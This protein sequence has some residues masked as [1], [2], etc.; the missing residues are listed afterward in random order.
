[1]A[2]GNPA[3]AGMARSIIEN[4]SKRGAGPSTTGGAGGIAPAMAQ[5]ALSSRMNE[6]QGSDPGAVLR[7]LEQMKQDVVQLIPQVAFS[8][9]GVSKHLFTVMKGLDGAIKEAEQATS[10]QQ[11]TQSVPIGMSVAQPP[12][13]NAGETPGGGGPPRPT[14]GSPF[15][16][17]GMR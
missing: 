13:S 7:K 1:M 10:T 6:L 12:G 14:G 15:L 17:G 11:A 2:A 9:P 4:L 3:L 8:V 16:T 5:Q